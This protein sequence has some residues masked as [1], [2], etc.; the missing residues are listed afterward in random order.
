LPSGLRLASSQLTAARP[1]IAVCVPMMPAPISAPT[2]YIAGP[3]P[4]EKPKLP[5]A[6][7]PSAWAPTSTI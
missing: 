7:T 2:M 3:V 5:T 1:N 4:I 6:T